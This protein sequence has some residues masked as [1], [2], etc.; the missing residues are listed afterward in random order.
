MMEAGGSN[1]ST[2]VPVAS[3]LL[4]Q[5]SPKHEEPTEVEC[6]SDSEE[7][8]RDPTIGGVAIALTHGSVLFE[9][10]KRELHAT[11]SLIKPVRQHPTR[12]SLVFYQHKHMNFRH[13]GLEEYERKM[14]ARQEEAEETARLNGETP[15]PRKGRKRRLSTSDDTVIP[16]KTKIKY[17]TDSKKVPTKGAPTPSTSTVTTLTS[18]AFPTVTGPYQKWV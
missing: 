2:P 6:T 10:A 5:P 16:D 11:T 1:P 4:P 9:V 7:C 13:H 8:F 15:P 12:I 18:T 17:N 14:Q 3:A